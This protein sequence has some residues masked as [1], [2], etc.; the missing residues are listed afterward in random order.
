LSDFPRKTMIIAHAP[1]G[2]LLA[3][4]LSSTMSKD[5]AHSDG[6]DRWH[7]TFVAAGILGGIFPDFDLI[8]QFLFDPLV[9]SHHAYFTHLPVF[10]LAAW[11]L[12]SG[13]GTVLKNRSF[14][15]LSTIFCL[16]AGLHLV[17][18]TLTGVI[19]W[20]YPISGKGI[21]V[22]KVADVHVW[23]VHNY[24]Y[25]WT[26]LF[27]IGIVMAAMLVFLRVR[28]STQVVMHLF[29]RQEKLRSLTLRLGV[30][31]FGL[32]VIAVV[33]SMKFTID[34]KAAAKIIKMKHYV[35][36]MFDS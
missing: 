32:A 16:S 11:G 7:H 21:N 17:L 3:R 4:L 10:W 5:L 29:R 12:L 8:Y 1:A 30:C 13:I 15:A 34:N 18:D 28:E 24:M 26:F 33:G 20:F 36:R 14:I 35:A 31:V 25:H 2:Y 27:E 6:K 9:D 23:W 19:F 22:F